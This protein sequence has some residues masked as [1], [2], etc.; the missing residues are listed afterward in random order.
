MHHTSIALTIQKIV[1][2]E[3]EDAGDILEKLIEELE[4]QGF[5]VSILDFYPMD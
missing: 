2:H 1:E 4:K 3:K 5:F